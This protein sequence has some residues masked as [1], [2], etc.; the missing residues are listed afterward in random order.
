MGTYSVTAGYSGDSNYVSATSNGVSEAVAQIT[1][2]VKLVS[3][4]ASSPVGSAV[5]FTATVTGISA[6]PMSGT[7]TFYAG[8]TAL[9]APA[10]LT[11]GVA[12]LTTSALAA[13]PQSI[14]AVYSGSTD[15]KGA[16]SNAVSETISQ[17]APTVNLGS[18]LNPSSLGGAVKLTATLTGVPGF[19]PTGTVT[20][21]SGLIALGSAVTVVNGAASLTTS[22]LTIGS[23]TITAVYS[24]DTDYN[25]ATSNAVTEPVGQA[26]PTVNLTASSAAAPLGSSVTFTATITGVSSI[27]PSG[28]VTFWVGAIPLG[29]AVTL[30]GG[31]ASLTTSILAVGN[32]SITAVYSGDANYKSA[33]SNKVV[34]AVGQA[35]PTVIL[36]SSANPGL[37]G[38]ATVFTA[39]MNGVPNTMPTG[40][41]T[42]YA[43]SNQIGAPVIALV[44]CK[45]TSSPANLPAGTS[46]IT[47][48]YSGDANY[49]KKTSPVLSEVIHMR[50]AEVKLVAS[51]N[52]VPAGSLAKFTATVTDSLGTPTPTGK[53]TFYSGTQAIGSNGP[54]TA[55]VA[56]FSTS[57]LAEGAETITASYTGDMLFAPVTSGAL[58]EQI[59]APDFGTVNVGTSMIATVTV[60][61]PSGGTPGGISVLTLGAPGLDFTNA[62]GGTCAV[63]SI[64]AANATCTVKVAFKPQHAGTRMGAV[65]LTDATAKKAILADFPINGVGMAPQAGF[66]YA[67]ETSVASG[68]AGVTALAVDGNGSVFVADNV[69]RAVYKETLASGKYSRT[70]LASGLGSP[71]GLAVDGSGNIYVADI[72]NTAKGVAIP[73]GLYKF[74]LSNGT[75]L[76]STIATGFPFVTA[77]AVDKNGS[78]YIADYAKNSVFKFTP[79]GSGFV[80]STIASGFIAIKGV[81]VDR[82]GSVFVSDMGD[83]VGHGV[84]YKETPSATGY[85]QSTIMAGLA[86][87]GNLAAPGTGAVYYYAGSG[88]SELFP[89]GIGAEIYDAQEGIFALDS[90]GNVFFVPGLQ[91]VSKVQMDTSAPLDYASSYYGAIG[92][93]HRGTLDNFGN[94]PLQFSAV[95]FPA[96]FPQAASH[97]DDCTA[98][99]KLAPGGYCTLTAVFH[100]TTS[101]NGAA[102]KVLTETISVKDNSL[103]IAGSTQE[104]TS[105]G[106]EDMLPTATSLASSANPA[107]VGTP[108]TLTALVQVE[109]IGVIPA[110]T[111]TFKSGTTALGAA[112]KLDSTGTA[113]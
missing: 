67:G 101:L 39:T 14:V 110:G 72:G 43:N 60:P 10:P 84:L 100:P 105:T 104:V 74:T 92:S 24:G 26:T 93:F 7:V 57:N 99:T 107:T 102:S 27:S 65:V 89:S 46:A 25:T 78:V 19:S 4:V 5:Q 45:A 18:S 95:S 86:Y 50:T 63:G 20:F 108:V 83:G 51:E 70:T 17:I 6:V 36:T 16:T 112:V 32:D 9:G 42:F 1:P 3:S 109:P 69:N 47:A 77:L 8:S 55:G 49:V 76:R 81:A 13:G 56:S 85:T 64:Y 97:P 79:S 62:L 68:F 2:T 52:P 113:K 28:N 59:T 30:S 22:A 71:N 53:V 96:D 37:A 40:T 33:T 12:S 80:Q 106:T 11:S 82:D 87:L 90:S 34:E 41:V 98:T 35:T 44:N 88:L 66:P 54:M 29:S 58:V 94:A 38:I 75:Y 103:N 15:Y 23:D 31:K 73:A 61:I 111:V 48:A 21:K 91:T